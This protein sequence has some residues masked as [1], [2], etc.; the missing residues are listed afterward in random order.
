MVAAKHDSTMD[1]KGAKELARLLEDRNADVGNSPPPLLE[2][3]GAPP[4]YHWLG[5]EPPVRE[6]EPDE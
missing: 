2:A 1:I 3:R 6:A 4:I 5:I